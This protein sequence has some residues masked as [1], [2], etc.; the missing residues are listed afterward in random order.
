VLEEIERHYIGCWRG[1][2]LGHLLNDDDQRKIQSAVAK[3][4]SKF[5][6]KSVDE[7]LLQV[8]FGS[9]FFSFKCGQIV[10]CFCL[11]KKRNTTCA[12]TVGF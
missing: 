2:M 8:S 11:K 9:V 4:V 1:T 3:I 5:S 12:S 7:Q 6:L 10:P